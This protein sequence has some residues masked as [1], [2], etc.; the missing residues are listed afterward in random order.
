[1]HRFLP[2]LVRMAGYRLTE[3][4][5]AHRPRS[6][7]RGKYGVNNRLWRGL[8]DTL[9]VRWLQDRHVRPRIQRSSPPDDRDARTVSAPHSMAVS[10]SE[11]KTEPAPRPPEE[12]A[13]CQE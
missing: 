13:C 1:M 2:T 3:V 9:G 5:V 6:Y 12:A 8:R 4:P 7:G 10:H 11:D